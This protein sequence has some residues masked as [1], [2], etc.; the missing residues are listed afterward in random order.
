M[1]ILEDLSGVDSV[2]IKADGNAVEVTF[3]SAAGLSEQGCYVPA[4]SFM[5]TNVEGIA[6]LNQLLGEALE[7]HARLG[8]AV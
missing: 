5:L 7:E 8:G 1:H 3:M 6:R 4:Q 2:R